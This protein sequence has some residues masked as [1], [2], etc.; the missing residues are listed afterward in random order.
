[1]IGCLVYHK[2]SG[3]KNQLE[4]LEDVI[5]SQEDTIYQYKAQLLHLRTQN[6][7]KTELINKLTEKLKEFETATKLI[8]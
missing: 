7:R 8:Q 3:E 4:L 5:K 1:V 2:N 6:N